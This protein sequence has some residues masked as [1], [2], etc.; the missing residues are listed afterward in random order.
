[1]LTLNSDAH[2]PESVGNIDKA[3][4]IV[5]KYDVDPKRIINSEYC[6]FKFKSRIK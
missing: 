6:E 2:K 4:E 5:N 3:L 1:M